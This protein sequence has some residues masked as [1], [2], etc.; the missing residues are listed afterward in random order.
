[1]HHNRLC[2][3]GIWHLLHGGRSDSSWLSDWQ[4]ILVIRNTDNKQRMDD[5]CQ[6][7][8]PVLVIESKI[9]S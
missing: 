1:M 3:L 2:T 6:T 8:A 7:N 9:T 5:T 4:L